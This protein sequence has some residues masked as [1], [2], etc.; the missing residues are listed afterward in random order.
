M[1]GICWVYVGYMCVMRVCVC[2]YMVSVNAFICVF[3][4]VQYLSM[5]ARAPIHTLRS[6]QVLR[7]QC[8]ELNNFEF[9]WL[10]KVSVGSIPWL[11]AVHIQ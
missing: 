6:M 10:S 2:R 5:G 3:S 8:Q 9:A 7:E 11:V 4:F 1:L